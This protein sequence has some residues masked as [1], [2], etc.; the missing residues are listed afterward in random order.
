MIRRSVWTST[1]MVDGKTILVDVF[2]F[3]IYFLLTPSSSLFFCFPFC[4]LFL[5]F[6]VIS[7][8]MLYIVLPV[9]HEYCRAVSRIVL[10]ISH[11][12]CHYFAVFHFLL[13]DSDQMDTE[14]RKKGSQRR[15]IP[16]ISRSLV[17][18][19]KR[20]STSIGIEKAIYDSFS[21]TVIIF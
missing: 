1:L 15:K 11:A 17:C 10:L 21:S 9:H 7:E 18:S 5:G 12:C 13:I 8:T 6:R 2:F 19:F 14:K 16:P 4:F 3:V 20:I